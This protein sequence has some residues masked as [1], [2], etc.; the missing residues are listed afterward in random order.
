MNVEEI[1][2]SQGRKKVEE[3]EEGEGIRGRDEP[4]ERRRRGRC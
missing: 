3:G 1:S 4:F 2:S